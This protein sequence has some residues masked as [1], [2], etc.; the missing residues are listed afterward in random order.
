[1]AHHELAASNDALEE[2]VRKRTA[3]LAS[4]NDTLSI[5]I[6]VRRRTEEQLAYLASHDYL[7]GL[8][9][10]RRFEEDVRAEILRADRESSSGAVVW[11]DLD[12]FKEFNDS[13]GHMA[14]DDILRGI[15][16]VLMENVRGYTSVARL[17]GDEFALLLPNV[18][19]EEAVT[20]AERVLEDLTAARIVTFEHPVHLKASAGVAVFPQHAET[21]DDLLVRADLALY[22]A[23][24]VRRGG[25]CVYDDADTWHSEVESRA[26]WI[27][28][29]DEALE[30]DRFAAWA[31]PIVQ[32]G[33]GRIVRYELLVRMLDANG[34][35]ILPD[36]FLPAAEA[37]GRIGQ[38]DRWMLATAVSAIAESGDGLQ[39]DVNISGRTFTDPTLL[40]YIGQRIADAGIPAELLGLEITETAAV[41]D[42]GEARSFIRDM[43]GLGC[44]VAL[45]DFGTGF[46]SLH[47][48]KQF[49]F[50]SMKIDGSFV[51]SLETNRQDQH[52]VKAVVEMARGLE[53]E[54]TAEHVE[55]AGILK[56]L[57]D[58]G[59]DLA[60]GWHTGLPEPLDAV[61]EVRRTDAPGAARAAG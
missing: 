59:V 15:A 47:Y 55:N 46:S 23:K 25:V 56:L 2:N 43:R 6:D 16:G 13:L 11:I 38:I 44:R 8:I 27:H 48:L 40:G 12:D 51:R 3:E 21:V 41:A 33:S 39:L 18:D 17:G 50:D 37:F 24:H 53:L 45:D 19:A 54:V 28:R 5:E 14:G 35:V 4:A 31:Q 30:E 58:L 36:E 42:I 1:T 32:I 10:R 49:E 61:I 22:H 60:Q 52:L 26:S 7:T 9:G 57:A 34:T 20:V 29:I